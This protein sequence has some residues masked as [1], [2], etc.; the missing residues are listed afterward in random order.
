MDL[1]QMRQFVAVAEELHFSR[2]AR[3]LN[4]A[5]PPLSQSI[6]RLE[7]ELGVRLLDRS[8]RGVWLD[9]KSVV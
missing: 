8:R 7:D 9:R 3:R 2:A 5:Q 6:K 1:R 4:M